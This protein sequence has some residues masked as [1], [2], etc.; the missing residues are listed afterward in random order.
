MRASDA[1]DSRSRSTP[2]LAAAAD[3][4]TELAAPL[5]PGRGRVVVW[6]TV[7]SVAL[8]ALVLLFLVLSK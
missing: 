6:T 5:A 1:R 3:E 2:K 8:T 7:I 4:P